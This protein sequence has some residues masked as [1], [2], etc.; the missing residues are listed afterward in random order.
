MDHNDPP[1]ENIPSVGDPVTRGGVYN[2][3]VWEDD[4]I[5]PSKA[6][7]RRRYVPKLLS[8]IHSVVTNLT[9][10]DYFIILFLMGY[11]KGNM[12]PRINRF[13]HDGSPHVSEHEFIKWLGV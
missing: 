11:V 7:K 9:L 13:L 4:G 12:L 2:E 1:E 3:E 6:A 8:F 5:N 10:S